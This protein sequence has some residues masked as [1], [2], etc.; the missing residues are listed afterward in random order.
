MATYQSKTW[1]DTIAQYPT[2]YKMKHSD[3]TEEQV[4]MLN[5]FG[6]ITQSGDVF[7]GAT[8]NNLESRISAGFDTCI[9]TLTGTTVPTS[10]EGKNGDLYIQT[11]T[12][13]NETSVVGMFVKILG[14]WLEIQTGGATLPQAEGGAF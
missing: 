8:F 5:D 13:G 11:E 12:V 6:T 7:D 14:A 3:L 2:R 9:D 10:S 1:L 4:E